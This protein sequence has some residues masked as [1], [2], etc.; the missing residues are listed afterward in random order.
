MI[1]KR[2]TRGALQ[3]D[4]KRKRMKK[5][6]QLVSIVYGKHADSVW[7]A[8]RKEEW[9]GGVVY[10]RTD[11]LAKRSTVSTLTLPPWADTPW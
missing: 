3:C 5:I 6:K 4:D 7:Q 11:A 8:C 2:G 10:D 1:E 9:I